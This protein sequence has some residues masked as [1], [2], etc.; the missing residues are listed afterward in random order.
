MAMVE[1][2]VSITIPEC[3]ILRKNSKIDFV[4]RAMVENN[5]III[6]LQ[7]WKRIRKQ[8]RMKCIIWH[9]KHKD[10]D[11]YRVLVTLADNIF[12]ESMKFD[13][14][15]DYMSFNDWLRQMS[16]NGNSFVDRTAK[17]TDPSLEFDKNK[18]YKFEV[19]DG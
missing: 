11:K 1:R 17:K 18:K 10:F 16:F 6:D 2:F 14:Y 13:S 5:E 9:F 19:I 8:K 12:M 4:K 15:N 7:E 3:V